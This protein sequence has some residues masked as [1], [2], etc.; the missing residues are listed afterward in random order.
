MNSNIELNSES[1]TLKGESKHLLKFA[2]AMLSS[3]TRI[4]RGLALSISLPISVSLV[5]MQ[6]RRI[7]FSLSS[8][9]L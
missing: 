3:V 5:Q 8:H 9:S 2:F 6:N 7:D 1:L 4:K